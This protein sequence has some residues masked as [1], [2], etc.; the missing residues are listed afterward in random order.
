MCGIF[1]FSYNQ[2]DKIKNI[3]L[4]NNDIK[5]FA[6]LSRIR[7]S[8]SFGVSISN[9]TKDFIYKINTDPKKAVSSK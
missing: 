1:G 7:G 8:Y 5:L 9:S 4:I 2:S 3:S 6:K